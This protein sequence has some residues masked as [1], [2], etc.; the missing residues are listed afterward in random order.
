MS[1]LVI[2]AFKVIDIKQDN[3]KDGF[4][5]CASFCDS[6]L[7]SPTSKTEEFKPGFSFFTIVKLATCALELRQL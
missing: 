7:A 4:L 5:R 3:R 6:S 2:E 1:K